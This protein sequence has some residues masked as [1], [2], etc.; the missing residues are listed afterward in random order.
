[1]PRSSTSQFYNNEYWPTTST[2][3]T[4]NWD[5]LSATQVT[6]SISQWMA[7]YK[8][9][10]RMPENTVPMDRYLAGQSTDRIC[11]AIPAALSPQNYY[12]QGRMLYYYPTIRIDAVDAARVLSRYY[13]SDEKVKKL[14]FLHRR[15]LP[16]IH[17]DPDVA[18]EFAK[19][20]ELSDVLYL[21]GTTSLVS[22]FSRGN[23]KKTF[24]WSE[25]KWKL[26]VYD[27][28]IHWRIINPA[29]PEVHFQ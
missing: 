21:S 18:K 20:H 12:D 23:D 19:R 16:V 14:F 29:K 1:M 27:S 22:H 11:I 7:W 24:K 13:D 28:K 25:G 3:S 6:R 15:A 4:A 2:T 9:Q 5:S 26:F 8:E 10:R 17:P